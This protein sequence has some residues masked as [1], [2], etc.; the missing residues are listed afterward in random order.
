MGLVVVVFIF[1][2]GTWWVVGYQQVASTNYLMA[3]VVAE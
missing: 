3:V 1:A 2:G